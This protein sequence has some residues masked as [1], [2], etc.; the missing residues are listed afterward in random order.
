MEILAFMRIPAKLNAYSGG[1]PQHSGNKKS[2]SHATLSARRPVSLL[3]YRID[4]PPHNGIPPVDATRV[5]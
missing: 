1:N 5:P 4:A 3:S 2:F